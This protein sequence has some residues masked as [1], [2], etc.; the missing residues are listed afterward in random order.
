MSRSDSS[1]YWTAR[2]IEYLLESADVFDIADFIENRSDDIPS[3][4]QSINMASEVLA[5]LEHVTF[6]IN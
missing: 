5:E 1:D 6:T 4:S 3:R 2:F